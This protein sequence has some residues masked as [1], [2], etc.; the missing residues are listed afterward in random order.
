MGPAE[1]ARL[2]AYRLSEVE[3]MTNSN[4]YPFLSKAQIVAKLES[5]P[6]FVK[7]A[8]LILTSR[9]TEDELA[10]HDTKWKNRRGWMSSHAHFGTACAEKIARDEELTD[11][12]LAK[13]TGMVCK[14]RKQL[15]AHFRAEALEA[16]PDL[17]DAGKIFGVC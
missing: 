10:S 15:A 11:A 13:L 7:Q 4:N 6:D 16:N 12:E 5:E 1:I 17:A 2:A 3:T 14:Y 9:Q 8:C